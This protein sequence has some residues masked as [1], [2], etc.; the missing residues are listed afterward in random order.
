MSA[1]DVVTTV[2]HFT[3]MLIILFFIFAV[4]VNSQN[5]VLYD[6]TSLSNVYGSEI[7]SDNTMSKWNIVSRGNLL[8]APK[9]DSYLYTVIKCKDY[10]KHQTIEFTM[11]APLDSEFTISLQES[12]ND[13]TRRGPDSNINTKDFV[14]FDNTRKTFSVPLSRFNNI[15]LTKVW[16][17]VLHSFN[18]QNQDYTIHSIRI[19]QSSPNKW[20]NYCA[21]KYGSEHYL[22]MCVKT[23]V[24]DDIVYSASLCPNIPE[25]TGNVFSK[26]SERCQTQLNNNLGAHWDFVKISQAEFTNLLNEGYAYSPQKLGPPNQIP[27]LTTSYKATVATTTITS[28]LSGTATLITTE[29]INHPSTY[30]YEATSTFNTTVMVPKTIISTKIGTRTVG[31]ATHTFVEATEI[32]TPWPTVAL[33]STMYNATVVQNNTSINIITKMVPYTSIASNVETYTDTF[34]PIYTPAP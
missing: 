30:T 11:T 25:L 29:A 34:G 8:F 19:T 21:Y 26:W 31:N 14:K 6:A 24:K 18:K 17:L 28:A 3:T 33:T 9:Q 16:A 5:V 13:C 10:S 4:V 12:N 27:L 15:N 7:S 22:A 32:V 20:S 1:A 23:S 2:I